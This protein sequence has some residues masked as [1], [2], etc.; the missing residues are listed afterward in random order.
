MATNDNKILEFINDE[1]YIIN[2]DGTILSRYS[3]QGHLTEK[4]RQLSLTD[5]KGYRRIRY[6][7]TCLFAHR[8]VYCK[9]VGSLKPNLTINH[10]DGNPANNSVDNLEMVT[11]SE[12]NLHR[13]RVLKKPGVIGFSKINFQIADQIRLEHSKGDS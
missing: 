6:K 12:N 4:W 10:I 7:G 13:F 3:R 1:N 5:N 8:I 11:Q 9:W 2:E